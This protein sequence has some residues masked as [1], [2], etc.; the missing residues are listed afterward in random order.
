M[1]VYKITCMMLL[2]KQSHGICLVLA[3]DVTGMLHMII[4]SALS[5]KR[6]CSTKSNI[7]KL[8]R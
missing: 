3:L 5:H 1:H 2:Y 4:V 8:V 6:I 7:G